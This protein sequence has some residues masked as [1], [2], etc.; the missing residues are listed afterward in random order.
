MIWF[1]G[2]LCL[3]TGTTF[4][5]TLLPLHRYR[6]HALCGSLAPTVAV[7]PS[8]MAWLIAVL[9][10]VTAAGLYLS[11]GAS[12]RVVHREALRAMDA[13]EEPERIVKEMEKL[14]DVWPDDYRTRH[15]LAGAYMAGGRFTDAVRHYRLVVKQVGD[16]GEPLAQLAQALFAAEGNTVTEEV[17]QV[18]ARALQVAPENTIALALQGIVAFEDK[19]YQ[20][21][22]SSWQKLLSLT[23]EPQARKAL[24]GGISHALAQLQTHSPRAAAYMLV[25]LS[26]DETLREQLSPATQVVVAAHAPGT[27]VPVSAYS[28]TVA[29]L[30]RTV[31]LDDTFSMVGTNTLSDCELVD[32]SVRVLEKNADVSHP[33]TL[34]RINGVAVNSGQTTNIKIAGP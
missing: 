6:Q 2:G 17:R 13:I 26:I 31:L 12:D 4:F 32:I 7:R 20:Q 30:P 11:V 3:L 5:F 16:Q 33:K 14:L 21:A 19:R 27:T 18:T 28:I 22:V 24:D 8:R 10:P 34:D 29:D 9:L 25:N 15:M 23:P 1:F